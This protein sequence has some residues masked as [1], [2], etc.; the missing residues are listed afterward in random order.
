MI[1]TKPNDT[2]TNTTTTCTICQEENEILTNVDTMIIDYDDNNNNN[3]TTD[4]TWDT[5]TSTNN[6]TNKNDTSVPVTL[7]KEFLNQNNKNDT[8]ILQMEILNELFYPF[9]NTCSTLQRVF[10]EQPNYYTNEQCQLIQSTYVPTLCGCT[11]MSS[12]Y[13]TIIYC[14]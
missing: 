11:K 12:C 8:T 1:D 9:I 4:T 14:T 10:Y 3:N 6:N 7:L 2:T 13:V 5:T